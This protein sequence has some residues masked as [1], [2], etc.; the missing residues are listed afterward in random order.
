MNI[1]CVPASALLPNGKNAH[2][3]IQTPKFW[4]EKLMEMK[5][6]YKKIKIICCYS[7]E[8]SEGKKKFMFSN[9]DDN[10]KKYL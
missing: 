8:I 5:K 7:L 10:I 3:N 4:H 6:M 2:I 1:A 9:I